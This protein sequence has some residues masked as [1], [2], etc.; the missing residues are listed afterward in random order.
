MTLSEGPSHKPYAYLKIWI[1]MS[2]IKEKEA[3]PAPP[4]GMDENFAKLIGLFTVC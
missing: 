4:T 1:T 2:E 3:A